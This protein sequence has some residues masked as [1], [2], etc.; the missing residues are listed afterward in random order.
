MKEIIEL[1]SRILTEAPN[2]VPKDTGPLM[3][4]R[5][6]DTDGELKGLPADIKADLE[7]LCEKLGKAIPNDFGFTMFV[8]DYNPSLDLTYSDGGQTFGSW[9]VEWDTKRSIFDQ[10]REFNW[11]EFRK[12]MIAGCQEFDA[13]REASKHAQPTLPSTKT[14]QKWFRGPMETFVKAKRKETTKIHVL[15]CHADGIQERSFD[16]MESFCSKLP[17]IM[18]LQFLV[19]TVVAGGKPLPVQK[20][21]KLKEQALK[22][23]ES[24]PISHAKALGKL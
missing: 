17:D 16:D 19:I 18:T 15:M 1:N 13:M 22:E 4:T 10:L 20:I 12:R 24:M 9:P 6:R 11:D 8:G 23:L 7:G 2:A 14:I 5:E 3:V 21:E